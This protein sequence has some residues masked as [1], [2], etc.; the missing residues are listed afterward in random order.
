MPSPY[1]KSVV[2]KS[3]DIRR[4][5]VTGNDRDGLLREKTESGIRRKTRRRTLGNVM[6]NCSHLRKRHGT[7]RDGDGIDL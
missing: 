6:D 7:H 3:V 4:A 5:E 2:T 1:G